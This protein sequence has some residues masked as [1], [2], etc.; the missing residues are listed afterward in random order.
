MPPSAANT[1]KRQQTV[2]SVSDEAL[3][4]GDKNVGAGSLHVDDDELAA[5]FDFFDV[6]GRGK[7]TVADLKARLGAFYK[8]LPSKEYKALISEPNFTKETLRALLANNELGN[9]DPVKE[10]FKVGYARLA[11]NC[12]RNSQPRVVPLAR[13]TTRRAPA[14]SI[15]RPCA[16]SS[17]T[18]GTAR[19][20]TRTSPSSSRRRTPTATEKSVSTTSAA[21]SR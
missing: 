11:R 12:A 3:K 17:R 9:Y 7:L 10:A 14:S 18:S 13:S 15:T 8:N 1:L 19:S 5:A 20:P 2:L 6:E 21:C 4:T 16:P